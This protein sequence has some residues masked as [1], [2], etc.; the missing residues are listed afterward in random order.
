MARARFKTPVF[1]P[2]SD[3][4]TTLPGALLNFYEA[5]SLT[6]RKDTFIQLEGGSANTNPVVADGEGRFPEIYLDGE[7]NVVLTDADANEIWDGGNRDDVA[8]VI[9]PDPSLLSDGSAAAPAY[10][11]ENNPDMGRYRVSEDVEGIAVGGNQV[12]QWTV[13]GLDITVTGSVLLPSLIMQSDTTTGWYQNSP[14]GWMFTSNAEDML[15]LTNGVVTLTS[16]TDASAIF[17][18]GA[19]TGQVS[20]LR[21]SGVDIAHGLTDIAPTDTFYQLEPIL[22][23]AGGSLITGISAADQEAMIFQAIIGNTNPTNSTPALQFRV[24]KSDGGTG[25][26]DLATTET[27]L[28]LSNHDG[29]IDYLTIT[30]AGTQTLLG[31]LDV[32]GQIEIEDGNVIIETA[33]KGIDFSAAAGGTGV[34]TSSLLDDYEEGTFLP[35]LWDSS[36]NGSEGQIYTLQDGNYTKIGE[37]VFFDATIIVSDKGTLTSG[38]AASIGALPYT[39]G[40]TYD[41]QTYT[42]AGNGSYEGSF[43]AGDNVMGTINQNDNFVQMARWGISTGATPLLIS[44]ITLD[45]GI[46]VSGSYV[47]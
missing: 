43:T 3:T 46:T 15:D 18:V 35:E 6:V 24:G 34:V 26:Q 10:S 27:A 36:L 44:N 33:G 20:I 30:G 9:F 23:T 11:Y 38:D 2:N 4:G 40:P 19:K 47:V 21:L 5:G 28:K 17:D 42:G 32:A 14:D 37:R 45:S 31:E 7:Y 25:A 39:S 22:G 12:A 1:S 13:N 8:S 29:T 16:S 41:A